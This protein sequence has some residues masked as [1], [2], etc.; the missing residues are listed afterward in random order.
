MNLK[1]QGKALYPGNGL[2]TIEYA[3]EAGTDCRPDAFFVPTGS[4]GKPSAR[5]VTEI[6]NEITSSAS[7]LRWSP[8]ERRGS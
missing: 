4:L 8:M 3:R 6:V 5:L 2:V 7:T 1:S